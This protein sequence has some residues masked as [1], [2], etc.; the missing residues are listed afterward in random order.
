MPAAIVSNSA[1]AAHRSRAAVQM[2][3]GE[4]VKTTLSCPSPPRHRNVGLALKPT[5]VPASDLDRA[6]LVK[7]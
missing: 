7:A 5:F 6:P 2:P 3:F 4:R 1:Y